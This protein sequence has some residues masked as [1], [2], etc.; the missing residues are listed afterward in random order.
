MPLSTA[1]RLGGI[2]SRERKSEKDLTTISGL[3]KRMAVKPSNDNESET[4]N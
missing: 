1:K 3:S 4:L 2:G